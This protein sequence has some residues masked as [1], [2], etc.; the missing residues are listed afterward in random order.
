M[1]IMQ[2][3]FFISRS[4]FSVVENDAASNRSWIGKNSTFLNRP[5]QLHLM[6]VLRQGFP[7]AQASCSNFMT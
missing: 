1:N 3:E 4:K 7:L 2:G 6:N 5:K